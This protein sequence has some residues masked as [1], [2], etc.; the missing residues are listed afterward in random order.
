[1]KDTSPPNDPEAEEAVLGSLLIDRDAV[2][3]VTPILSTEDFYLRK[4]GSVYQAILDLYQR[5]EP[6]DFVTVCNELGRGDRLEQCGG[7]AYVTSLLNA[8]PTPAHALFYANIVREAALRRRMIRTAGQIARIAYDTSNDITSAVSSAKTLV[9]DLD[10]H[11]PGIKITQ[12]D[13]I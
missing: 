12:G 1:M 6:A 8:V 11:N 3:K 13:K 5:H 10:A 7:R 2:V 9:A 4:N